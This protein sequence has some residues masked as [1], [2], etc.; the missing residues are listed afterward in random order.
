MKHRHLVLA[1]IATLCLGICLASLG[2]EVPVVRAGP[3]G[4]AR[5]HDAATNALTGPPGITNATPSGP[6]HEHEKSPHVHVL[7]T[8]AIAQAVREGFSEVGF[9]RLSGFAATTVTDSTGLKLTGTIPDDIKSLDGKRAVVA[10]FMRPLTLHE[11]LVTS[12]LLLKSEPQ[13]CLG[14]PPQLN[15]WVIVRMKNGGVKSAPEKPVA[16]CGDLRVGE[17]REDG[18]LRAI[19]V[20]DGESVRGP[21]EP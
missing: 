13:C 3:T 14:G 9:E 18:R 5:S 11:G 15:E 10:G 16:V 1:A 20:M 21:D 19:Y 4:L 2:G 7:P 12:F 6:D 17:Y 8:N